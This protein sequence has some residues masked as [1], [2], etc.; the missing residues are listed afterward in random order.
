MLC[1]IPFTRGFLKQILGKRLDIEDLEEVDPQLAR[2]L[3]HLLQCGEE[4]LSYL[5]QPFVFEMEHLGEK[6]V[7]ELVPGGAEIIVDEKNKEE[8][9][10]SLVQEMLV[11]SV[12]EQVK[13]FSRGFY[14]VL[15]MGVIK[16]FL[17]YELEL[18]V[19]G[20]SEIGVEDLKSLIRYVGYTG[21]DNII[22]W[23]WEVMEEYTE[24]ERTSFLFFVTGNRGILQGEIDVFRVISLTAKGIW[25]YKDCDKEVLWISHLSSNCSYMVFF[26]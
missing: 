11:K 9:V 22:K 15:P 6:I 17:P 16:M 2:S 8:Y 10:S 7:Q 13:E 1:R 18:L 4:D 20:R 14:E 12:S 21:K 26:L 19:C 5:E 23:F 3:K 25:R 24:E